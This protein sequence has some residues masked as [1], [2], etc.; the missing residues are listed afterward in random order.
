MD[1]FDL[2]ELSDFTAEVLE[3]G[4]EMYPKMLKKDLKK[5]G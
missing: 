3:I 4:K 2:S 1:G 5:M